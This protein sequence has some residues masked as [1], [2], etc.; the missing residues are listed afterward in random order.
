MERLRVGPDSPYITARRLGLNTLRLKGYSGI[1]LE[2]SKGAAHALCGEDGSGKTELLLT[3]AGRMLRTE[4]SLKVGDI[5]ASHLKG[6]DQL[7]KRAGLAF[8]EHVNDVERGLRVKTVTSAELSLA[9]KPSRRAATEAYLEYWGIAEYADRV[10][11]E[12]DA[13]TYDL[14]GIALGMAGDPEVLVVDDIENGLT[15]HQTLKLAAQL[16]DLA[17]NTGTTVVCGVTDYDLAAQFDSAT[18][19]SEGARAQ[20]DA[21]LR[22]HAER[23]VA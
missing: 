9:G 7:R 17:H 4:G 13:Y 6:V 1:D 11:E 2:V 10:I 5:D 23:E 8:F 3:L 20:R 18:C 12:L 15:E 16:R 19:L 14:L 22:R 21:Y